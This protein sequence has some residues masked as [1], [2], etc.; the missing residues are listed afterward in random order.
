MRR[1]IDVDHKDLRI[2]AILQGDGRASYAEIAKDLDMSEAA[3]YS[4]I[5]KLLKNHVI[6]KI[7]AILDPEKLGYNVTA[8]IAV[9]AQPAKYT[10]VLEDLSKISEVLEVHDV[11]GQHYCLVKVRTKDK[12]ELAK[13]LDKIGA[14]DGII[15]TETR[16]VLRTIKESY[17]LPI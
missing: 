16:I 5:Q 15:S 12:E 2:L 6:K 7:Q 14:L 3:V 1:K 17:D 4:R 8:F 13:I 11:T 10:K 9:T